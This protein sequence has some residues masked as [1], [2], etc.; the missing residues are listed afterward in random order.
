MASAWGFVKGEYQSSP[1]LAH[2]PRTFFVLY[3][4]ICRKQEVASG[5]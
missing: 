1:I 3:L 4:F 5:Y 2:Y